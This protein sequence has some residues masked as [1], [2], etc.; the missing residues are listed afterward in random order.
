MLKSLY[1]NGFKINIS[2]TYM[3]LG[4]INF[5]WDKK[6]LG[7]RL[8]FQTKRQDT[9]RYTYQVTNALTQEL[10]GEVKAPGYESAYYAASHAFPDVDEY[11]L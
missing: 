2:F 6:W 3:F 8:I 10:L 4:Q 5:K 9:S 7:L 1:Y 11:S